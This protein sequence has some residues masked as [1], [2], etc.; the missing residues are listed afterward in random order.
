M[1]Q[2]EIYDIYDLWYVPAWWEKKSTWLIAGSCVVILLVFIALYYLWERKKNI[3]ETSE[4]KALKM[5]A[6]LESQKNVLT[7]QELYLKITA[8]LKEIFYGRYGFL[9]K[10]NTDIEFLSTI[11]ELSISQD[12]HLALTDI[13]KGVELIK[14]AHQKTVISKRDEDL[15]RCKYI[16][17]KVYQKESLK[18]D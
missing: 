12:I 7:H 17:E 2:I 16:I 5:L 4:Q 9:F 1:S 14:F 3:R 11:K 8:L 10:G 13:L 18:S 15:I 6:F